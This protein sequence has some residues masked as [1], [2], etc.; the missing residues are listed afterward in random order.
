MKRISPLCLYGMLLVACATPLPKEATITDY[1]GR[2]ISTA[3]AAYGRD[4]HTETLP[5]GR[6]TYTWNRTERVILGPT[7][8]KPIPVVSRGG[9]AVP[10]GKFIP[11]RV[12]HYTCIFSLIVDAGDTV[13]GWRAV[14]AGCYS[15]MTIPASPDATPPP[16][17]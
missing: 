11:P 7:W 5:D 8:D 14:G 15:A 17:E 1:L 16:K 12:V 13:V 10:L 9:P 6:K 4:Y 2:N 3:L